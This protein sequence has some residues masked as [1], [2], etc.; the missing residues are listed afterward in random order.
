MVSQCI[1]IRQVPRE[2]LKTAA[3]KIMFDPYIIFSQK[4]DLKGTNYTRRKNTRIGRH[5]LW[6]PVGIPPPPRSLR[7]RNHFLKGIY[8][9]FRVDSFQKGDYSSF[10]E[11]ASSKS[12]DVPI[13]LKWAELKTKTDSDERDVSTNPM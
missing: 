5:F 7:S 8:S 3:W 13:Q 2:V 9:K 10:V 11:I 12:V 6:L 4:V 1:N